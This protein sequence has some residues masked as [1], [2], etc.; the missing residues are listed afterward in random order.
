MLMIQV[1]RNESIF[2]LTSHPRFVEYSKRLAGFRQGLPG[3]VTCTTDPFDR[4][5]EEKGIGNMSS[6]SIE[7]SYRCDL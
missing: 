3:S 1:M 4:A 2:S 7:F 5:G 6:L